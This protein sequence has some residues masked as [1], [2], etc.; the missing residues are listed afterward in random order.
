L[1]LTDQRIINWRDSRLNQ[2]EETILKDHY[3][4][5]N[6]IQNDKRKQLLIFIYQQNRNYTQ[7]NEFSGLKP[8]SLYHHLKILDPLIEKQAH[9]LYV[10]TNLGR[11][12][13]EELKL[14]DPIDRKPVIGNALVHEQPTFDSSN[15]DIKKQEL[16]NDRKTEVK[17]TAINWSDPL[18]VIWIGQ[19]S[20]FLIGTTFIVMILLGLQGISFAGS[21]IY[22]VEG[23]IVFAFDIVAFL[24]GLGSL[25]YIE[26]L[27]ARIEVYNR[28]K[29]IFTIRIIS[30]IPGIIVGIT[31]LLIYLGGGSI[32]PSIFPMIFVFT[33]F[34]GTI[35]AAFGI[36][37][38]RSQPFNIAILIAVI[39]GFIDLIIG[40][41]VLIA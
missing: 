18:A 11:K 14:I 34:L 26:N 29:F 37:Y 39:P 23:N 15:G 3:E 7:L 12:I 13:V 35:V 10:I 2:I 8:G 40:G 41:I 20:Y 25:W 6:R 17:N 19:S 30:M 32:T 5:Y 31:L 16:E 38:L 21:A 33:I 1:L 4:L 36:H 27:T 28:I 9:G 24:L 22:A